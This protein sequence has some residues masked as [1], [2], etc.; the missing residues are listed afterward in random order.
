MGAIDGVPKRKR[1]RAG[2]TLGDSGVSVAV[3]FGFPLTGVGVA[4][5]YA[6]AVAGGL[7]LWLIGSLALG[8]GLASFG[9]SK[10]L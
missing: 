7:R 10:V 3:S 4:V 2:A 5:I 8:F 9:S 6:A 1:I